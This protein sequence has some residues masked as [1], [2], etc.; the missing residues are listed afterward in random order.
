MRSTPRAIPTLAQD[1][2]SYSSG[3]AQIT[4][5]EAQLFL[6]YKAL[7]QT[8]LLRSSNCPND[9]REIHRMWEYLRTYS[10][11]KMGTI[12]IPADADLKTENKSAHPESTSRRPIL[13]SDCIEQTP[14]RFI[15][16]VLTRSGKTFPGEDGGS[17]QPS[18][19]SG[20]STWIGNHYQDKVQTDPA[21]ETNPSS[22]YSNCTGM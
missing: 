16:S 4:K 13:I 18:F 19:S 2:T 5:L 21:N 11:C 1:P 7:V 10:R 15:S 17:V 14:M 9:V 8:H 6:R 22:A 12:P 3:T 20:T